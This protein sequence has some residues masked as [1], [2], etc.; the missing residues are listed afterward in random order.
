MDSINV[1]NIKKYNKIG[2]LTYPLVKSSFTPLINLVSI[3]NKSS[4][5]LCLIAPYQEESNSYFQNI[6]ATKMI[7]FKFTF[8]RSLL[9]N[10]FSYLFLQLRL[11]F[12][13]FHNNCDYWF[14]FISETYILPLI[15][16]K[17][18]RK[19]IFLVLGNNLIKEAKIKKYPL[20]SLFYFIRNL[21]L[22]L[23]NKIIIYSPGLISELKIEKYI[24][25]KICIAPE[26]FIN[27]N[28]FRIVKPFGK[29]KQ[30]VGFIGR[31]SEEKGVSNLLHAIPLLNFEHNLTFFI[32]GEGHL[33]KEI[34]EFVKNNDLSCKIK[35]CNWIKH[36]KL[37]LLLNSLK[38]LILPSYSEGL[39]NILLESMSCGT[40][41]LAT[42]VGAIP[43]I[44]KDGETGFIME[45]NSPECIAQNII[46]VLNHPGLEQ[47]AQNARALVER[48]FTFEKAVE[49]Y[50]KIVNCKW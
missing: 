47:I 26:H 27:T 21:S 9:L 1:E 32:V 43:D 6:E 39:P 41:V 13:I 16:A 14:F 8:K 29:R 33:E 18:L 3:L 12:Y 22:F 45:D 42:P 24:G 19:K 23:C 31:F 11:S 15:T 48:E 4:C 7:S 10:L 38:L 37:P 30:C 35:V 5:F 17:I 44:I 40:P 20:L 46:R 50:E 2:I 28:I 49:R 34:K 25:K 36:D